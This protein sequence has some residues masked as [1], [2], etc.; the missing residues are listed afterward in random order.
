[1]VTAPCK[2]SNSLQSGAY[3]GLEMVARDFELVFEN[4]MQYNRDDSRI[5]KVG[6]VIL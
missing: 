2:V 6:V 5:Y 3:V 4:A 1:M